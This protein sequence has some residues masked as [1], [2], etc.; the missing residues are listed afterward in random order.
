MLQFLD[1][2]PVTVTQVRLWTSRDPVLSAVLRYTQNGWPTDAAAVPADF[3]P[4]QQRM[5]ELSCQDGCVLWGGRIV[6]P[7][8]GR[9]K[10]LRLLHDGH[11]GESRTKTFERAYMWWPRMDDD[12][13]RVVS[14]CQLCN[15]RRNQS[16]NV[17][18]HPW[19]WPTRP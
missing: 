10:M 14:S 13:V 16:P 12:I 19:E 18:M 9:E 5:G 11:L 4:Y 17:P 7:P 1:S 8:Q 2:T 3:R 15:E 6:I